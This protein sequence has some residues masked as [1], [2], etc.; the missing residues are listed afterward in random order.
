MPA[1]VEPTP[2]GHDPGPPVQLVDAG[3][4]VHLHPD[5][6]AAAY[7]IGPHLGGAWTDMPEARPRSRA[8]SE[9]AV[10]V[11]IDTD[12]TL[13]HPDEDGLEVDRYEGDGYAD[14]RREGEERWARIDATRGDV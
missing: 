11:V 3:D 5:Q 12:G 8:R 4:G 14:V 7:M 1:P 6:I 13:H 2:H 9:V 10:T